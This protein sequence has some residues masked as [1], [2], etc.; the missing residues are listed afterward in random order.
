MDLLHKAI[1]SYSANTIGILDS[2]IP[3][4]KY[5][6]LNLSKH[7]EDLMNID[8]T[9]Y[10]ICQNYI[11]GVL[12]IEDGSVA[13]G[14]YLEQRNLYIDK[15]SFTSPDEP[16]R[17][18]HLGI[19]FWCNVGTKVVV[20]LAGKVHS[21]KNNNSMGDYG[22][23][24][25][26]EHVLDDIKFYTLYGHL[27]VASISGLIKGRV[28]KAGDI[29]ATLGDSD[30]NMNYAPHLHFQIIHDLEDNEGDYPGVCSEAL[31]PFYKANCPDPN[32][33]LKLTVVSSSSIK[34]KV[35][36]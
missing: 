27:A 7:N 2:A 30:I 8:I 13:C 18:I 20:P 34:Y 31:L 35:L 36:S 14:G 25:I 28:F 3:T 4:H 33:L 10:T 11:D 24:I 26:L 32:L 6:P 1:N 23:T 9:N 21:F 12:K 16:I 19:D 5:I 22:P 29:L 15:E 17:N